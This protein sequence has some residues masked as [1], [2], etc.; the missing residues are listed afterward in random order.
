[1]NN[2]NNNKTKQNSMLN[3]ILI[4]LCI[5]LLIVIVAYVIVNA[6]YKRNRAIIH[7]EYVNTLS[8]TLDTLSGVSSYK[9]EDGYTVLVI[10]SSGW[11]NSTDGDKIEYCEQLQVIVTSIRNE[12]DILSDGYYEMIFF[13]DSHGN[14]IAT[15]NSTGKIELK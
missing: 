8:S 14:D 11:N 6:L 1:M 12:Y 13:K 4:G 7:D 10:P 15:A 3:K 9:I 5:L 2:E